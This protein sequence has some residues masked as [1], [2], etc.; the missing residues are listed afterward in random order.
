M[1]RVVAPERTW[2]ADEVLAALCALGSAKGVEGMA[3][4]GISTRLTLGVPVP[5]ERALAKRIGTDHALARELW[6]TGVHEARQV[7]AMIDDPSKV[8]RAQMDRWARDLDSWDVCDGCA[9]DLF[10]RTPFAYE[11]ALEWSASPREYVKRASFATMAA[12]AVHDRQAPDDS[13][14]RFLP[15]IRREAGDERNFVKKAVNWALRQ[16]GKRNLALNAAAIATAEAIR[17]DGTRSGRWIAADALR[18]LRGEAV[19]RR[20]REHATPRPGEHRRKR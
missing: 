1:A 11:K 2:T 16:I 12:L 17:A 20:L 7:A 9:L 15:V 19:Q 3:R 10:R 8:T 14:L 5:A 18:E 13:M 6:A 4:F